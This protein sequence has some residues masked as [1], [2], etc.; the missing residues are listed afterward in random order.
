VVVT[1]PRTATRPSLHVDVWYPSVKVRG[2]KARYQIVPGIEIPA[3]LA[4]EGARPARGRFPLAL[5]SHGSEGFSVVATFFTEVLASHGYVVAAP[6]HPGDTIFNA[7]LGT[8]NTD[9]VSNVANRIGDLRRVIAAMSSAGSGVPWAIRRIVNPNRI[10]STGHSLGG[11]A[12]IGLAAADH[13]VGAVIA[14]DPTSF[15]LTPEQLAGVRVPVLLEWSRGGIRGPGPRWFSSLRRT[16]YQVQMPK[17][18]H[19]SFTDVCSYIPFLPKWVRVLRKLDPSFGVKT[20]LAQLPVDRVCRPPA[21]APNYVHVLADGYA[22]S[23]LAYVLRDRRDWRTTLEQSRP[24]ARFALG[25][26]GA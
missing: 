13:R 16:R 18:R 5:Y 14:M 1:V 20:L 17:A 2:P 10:V 11:T 3:R 8:T 21:M 6:D 4:V 24:G 12:A 7:V 19:L 15:L 22:F 26:R 23:Y 9:W 25:R